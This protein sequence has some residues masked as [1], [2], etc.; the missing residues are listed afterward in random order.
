M[1]HDFDVGPGSVADAFAMMPVPMTDANQFGPRFTDSRLPGFED[2][3][4]GS[5]RRS[6]PSD[7]GA[8]SIGSDDSEIEVSFVNRTGFGRRAPDAP[9]SPQ[10]RPRAS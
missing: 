7:F 8:S 5:R 4:R 2:S 10:T 9:P 3:T 6:Q 1:T